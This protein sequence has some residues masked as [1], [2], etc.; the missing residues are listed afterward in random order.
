[1]KFNIN[2]LLRVVQ[3][4]LALGNELIDNVLLS[5]KLAEGLLLPLNELI[6]VLNA[7]G[8]NL[9]G[10]AEHD[11]IQELNVGSQLITVS[12]AFPVQVNL[13]LGLVDV[14][15]QVLMALNQAIQLGNLFF[16]LLFCPLCHENFKHLLQPFLHL[17]AVEVFA[18]GLK[19]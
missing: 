10:G 15:D 2:N 9:P 7:A 4:S 12:V 1:M 14:G 17:L 8:S 13:D 5:L 18:E 3:E 6:N 11:S 19:L 16:P